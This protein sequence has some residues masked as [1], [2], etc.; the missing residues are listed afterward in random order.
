VT[1]LSLVLSGSPDLETQ[2]PSSGYEVLLSGLG[3]GSR[4]FRRGYATSPWVA[5]QLL[6]SA[7]PDQFTYTLAV[8][9]SGADQAEVFTRAATLTDRLEQFTYTLT[10]TINGVARVYT[11]DPADYD[12]GGPDESG[13]NPFWLDDNRLVV[14][15][16]IP[17]YPV[18]G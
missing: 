10:E 8:E 9:V 11:C 13:W 17:V 16:S 6:T 15:A 3:Q 7:V 5:G 1:T 2:D 18:I 4:T 12:L 14:R